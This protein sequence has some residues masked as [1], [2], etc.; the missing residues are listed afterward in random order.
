MIFSA[1]IFLAGFIDSI[2]GGGGLITLPVL[3]I[4]VGP[5]APAVGTNKI[6]ATVSALTALVIYARKGHFNY[7]SGINF[8]IACGVGTFFGSKTALYLPA[9]F[10]RWGIVSICPFLLYLIYKKDSFIKK[11]QAGSFSPNSFLSAK[12]LLAGFVCGFYDGVLGP[13]GGTL[14]LI[15]LVLFAHM[16]LLPALATSKL[17]NVVTALTALA[18]FS[19]A[20]VINWQIGL[21]LAVF[22]FLGSLIG[23][24]LASR[25]A[26]QVVRPVLILVVILLMAKLI[27]Y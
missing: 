2:A 18:N 5:G 14:M 8:V 17:A 4:L 27:W 26:A 15:S 25:K 10:F 6:L 22:I 3:T 7:K 24:H 9:D 21:K 23:S 11:T 12:L 1:L 16:P 19:M 20:R 13:G